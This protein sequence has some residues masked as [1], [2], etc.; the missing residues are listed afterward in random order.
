MTDQ[1]TT[2][3]DVSARERIFAAADALVA[4]GTRPTVEAV[5]QRSR[6]AM[7]AVVAVMREWRAER[8][9]ARAVADR[10]DVP[11]VVEAAA[12]EAAGK[13]YA[14]GRADA[15]AEASAALTAAEAARDD[16]AAELVEA[17][18][19]YD[20]LEQDRAALADTLEAVRA[21][22]TTTQG[23]VEAQRVEIDRLR[24]EV[25]AERLRADAGEQNAAAAR[26]DAGA[27][28]EQAEALRAE[29]AQVR[30]DATAEVK[31]AADTI[32]TQRTRADRAEAVADELRKTVESLTIQRDR[33]Q[34]SLDT[35][36]ADALAAAQAARVEAA[37]ASD[38]PGE[39]ETPKATG[40]GR[41]APK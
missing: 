15:A 11:Q 14:L 13:A 20:Q 36:H 38:T 6:A 2:A 37:Q 27:V 18:A 7:N 35:A 4:E 26:A 12:I 5:R 34:T 23:T 24:A 19:A 40:R 17:A 3:P 41:N 30:A 33:L 29:V 10:P 1:T 9:Q 16:A 21:T 8:E 32:A 28:R 31:A 25:A 22:L 39:T